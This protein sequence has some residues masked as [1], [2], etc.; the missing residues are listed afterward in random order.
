MHPSDSKQLNADESAR[1]HSKTETK[2]ITLNVKPSNSTTYLL[3]FTG[4]V[5]KDGQKRGFYKIRF[6]TLLKNCMLNN[7]MK[8]F[9]FR[10]RPTYI[11]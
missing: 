2:E 8:S 3:S 11:M 5:Y 7:F 10:N 4:D 6:F 9:D 1:F